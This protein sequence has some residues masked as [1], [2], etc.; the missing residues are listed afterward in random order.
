MFVHEL[1]TEL[2]L[3]P[4]HFTKLPGVYSAPMLNQSAVWNRVTGKNDVSVSTFFSN[5]LGLNQEPITT[6]HPQYKAQHLVSVS[7]GAH[8]WLWQVCMLFSKQTF[9]TYHLIYN[10]KHHTNTDWT[11]VLDSKLCRLVNT[12]SWMSCELELNWWVLLFEMFGP[13]VLLFGSF[14]SIVWHFN[15]NY[16]I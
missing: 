12:L 13:T 5:H 15:L 2:S 3:T 6:P 1:L 14:H 9:N 10:I 7:W 4:M 8:H 16:W 11:L